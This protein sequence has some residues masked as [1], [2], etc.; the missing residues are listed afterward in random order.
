MHTALDSSK[1]GKSPV[2]AIT[3][4]RFTRGRDEVLVCRPAGRTLLRRLGW[5]VFAAIAI[6]A[7]YAFHESL[8][9]P[10]TRIQPAVAADAQ[11]RQA[12][13]ERLLAETD[14]SLRKMMSDEE[15][16]EYRRKVELT[17]AQN[18]AERE[19]RARALDARYRQL[20]QGVA[21]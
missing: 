1:I 13:V 21:A 3:D 18:R 15:W 14:A 20:R 5:T 16:A 10:E 11:Q 2:Y 17:L 19:A 12:E 7:L 8:A 6:G 9:K 4:W